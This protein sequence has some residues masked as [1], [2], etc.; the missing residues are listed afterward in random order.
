MDLKLQQNDKKGA[1]TYCPSQSIDLNWQKPTQFSTS[2][3]KMEIAVA[4][5]KP[6]KVFIE[7]GPIHKTFELMIL[8]LWQALRE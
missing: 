2:I 5:V 6:S 4:N 8:F 1:N 7:E 3:S